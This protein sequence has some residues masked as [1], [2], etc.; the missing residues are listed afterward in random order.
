MQ[1]FSNFLSQCRKSKNLSQLQ[2]AEKMQVR[3]STV[4]NWESGK[5]I[6]SFRDLAKMSKL[7][8]VPALM[9]A[10]SIFQIF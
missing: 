4:S 9:L 7:L 3:Q 2:F 1:N 6:P 8:D 5:T 10:E